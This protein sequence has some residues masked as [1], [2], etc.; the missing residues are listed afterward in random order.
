MKR[1]ISEKKGTMYAKMML[2]KRKT[3]KSPLKKVI[4]A[5][6]QDMKEEDIKDESKPA[7]FLPLNEEERTAMSKLVRMMP[8]LCFLYDVDFSKL[9]A[10]HQLV[11]GVDL[12]WKVDIF[13]ADPLHNVGRDQKKNHAEYDVFNSNDMKHIFRVLGDVMKP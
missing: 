6:A 1:S 9:V 12:S 10:K 8:P 4:G 7:S 2:G 11:V 5:G 3:M 13:L